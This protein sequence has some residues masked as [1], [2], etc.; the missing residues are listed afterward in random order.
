MASS[1]ASFVPE[2]IEKCAVWAASPISTTFPVGPDACQ[3]AFLIAGKRRQIERFV[4]TRW[5]FRCSA[6]SRST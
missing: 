5:P 1:M 2:P 6:K 3:E 4:S